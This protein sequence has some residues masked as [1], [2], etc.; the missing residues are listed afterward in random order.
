MQLFADF[1]PD[2]VGDAPMQDEQLASLLYEW[3]RGQ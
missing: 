2:L 1:N 3:G